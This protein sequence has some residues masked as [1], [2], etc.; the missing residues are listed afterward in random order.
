MC[1]HAVEEAKVGR[2]E[3]Y[4]QGAT[5]RRWVGRAVRW[6]ARCGG[7]GRGEVHSRAAEMEKARRAERGGKKIEPEALG[8]VPG[9]E[10]F[11]EGGWR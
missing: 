6:P 4:M 5:M 9:R 1:V 7:H 3:V 2:K 11:A 8:R 10:R